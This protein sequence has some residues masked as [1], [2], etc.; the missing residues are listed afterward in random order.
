MANPATS[1]HLV[2]YPCHR[3]QYPQCCCHQCQYR[4][5]GFIKLIY[6]VHNIY[7]ILIVINQDW[8]L[9]GLAQHQEHPKVGSI[10]A[11]SESHFDGMMAII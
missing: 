6:Q 3:C 1:T 8:V 9:S 10:L 2:Q 4:S 7:T 11:L 5:Y